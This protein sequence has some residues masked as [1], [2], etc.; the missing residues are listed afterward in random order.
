MR[1][2]RSGALEIDLA[3]EEV[4]LDG[5]TVGLRGRSFDVLK[6]LVSR[7]PDLVS[8]AEILDTVWA[9]TPITESVLTTAIK[10]IRQALND[11]ARESAYIETRYGRGYRFIAPVAASPAD[12]V[13]PDLPRTPQFFDSDFP[14]LKTLGTLA[15]IVILVVV[16]T[17]LFGL[18]EAQDPARLTL[19]TSGLTPELDLVLEREL[20][21][22]GLLDPTAWTRNYRLRVS[23]TGHAPSNSIHVQL[24]TLENAEPVDTSQLPSAG[25][26]D[27]DIA[28]RI[29]LETR[30]LIACSDSLLAD[31]VMD[32]LDPDLLVQPVMRLCHASLSPAPDYD[33][34]TISRRILEQYEESAF[35]QALHVVTTARRQGQY[36]FGQDNLAARQVYAEAHQLALSA[37]AANGD[38]PLVR[39]AL[40]MTPEPGT[41]LRERLEVLNTISL[42]SWAGAQAAEQR[43]MMLRQLGRIA[44]ANF[45]FEEYEARW[46]GT[47]SAASHRL[48]LQAT[49][50]QIERGQQILDAYLT[51]HPENEGLA[52]LR[53]SLTLFYGPQEQ[54]DAMLTR[55]ETESPDLYACFE[56]Q[57][58][59]RREGR[60]MNGR[61]I[62][63]L[64]TACMSVDITYTARSLAAMGAPDRALDRF[65]QL[66]PDADMIAV[67]FYYPEL[68]AVRRDP[69]FTDIAESFGLLEYWRE[70]R[71]L[72]DFCHQQVDAEV[73]ARAVY[74][75]E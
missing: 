20:R 62:E 74:A 21:T 67:V 42:D 43:G 52:N 37:Q 54:A 1:I 64:E 48:I 2:F 29:S 19:V 6:L 41:R 40:A 18:R 73:C 55:V 35:A 46:P 50:G 57:W 12:S 58:R 61:E 49:M 44:E 34:L 16:L 25:M 68:A 27:S 60:L 17:G 11:P 39:V 26:T 5:V 71:T 70:T 8:K 24:E 65:E 75:G 22:T 28:R 59:S 69:R 72:P 10:E 14:D 53:D 45:L 7:A 47:R 56:P 36:F 23:T 51:L 63:F 15:G 38:H 3:A 31:A 32:G 4:R 33:A 66:S 13:S 9:D 30:T